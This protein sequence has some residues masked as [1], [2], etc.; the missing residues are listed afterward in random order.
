MYTLIQ[1][2]M[3]PKIIKIPYLEDFAAVVD[4]YTKKGWNLFQPELFLQMCFLSDN[5]W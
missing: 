3:W 2:Q 4:V 5:L 1:A